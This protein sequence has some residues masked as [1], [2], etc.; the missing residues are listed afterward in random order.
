MTELVIGLLCSA[1]LNRRTSTAS[2]PTFDVVVFNV[3]IVPVVE[4][5]VVIVP[6]VEFNVVIVPVVASNTGVVTLDGVMGCPLTASPP[7]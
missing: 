5:S 7:L 3:V 2:V 1:T 4:P 6:V